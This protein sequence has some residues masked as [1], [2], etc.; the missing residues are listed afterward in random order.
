MIY[1]DDAMQALN[2]GCDLRA[3]RRPQIE[4]YLIDLALEALHRNWNPTKN[5]DYYIILC[6]LQSITYES[7]PLSNP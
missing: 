3:T 2:N 7:P 5:E 1:D 6:A 4:P